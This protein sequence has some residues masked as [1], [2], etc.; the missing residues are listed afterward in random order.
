MG[1]FTRKWFQPI[2]KNVWWTIGFIPDKQIDRGSDSNR[3]KLARLTFEDK[4]IFGTAWR[5]LGRSSYILISVCGGWNTS[6]KNISSS[7]K[8]SW[9]HHLVLV[10]LTIHGALRPKIYRKSDL[11]QHCHHLNHCNPTPS[12]PRLTLSLRNLSKADWWYMPSSPREVKSTVF[13]RRGHV[14]PSGCHPRKP[15]NFNGNGLVTGNDALFKAAPAHLLTFFERWES[16]SWRGR[17]EG[18]RYCD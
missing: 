6:G 2:W 4:N 18:P 7:K 16:V 17:K 15:Q 13:L 11:F 9:K 14:T 12:Q 10:F 5:F 8:L 3:V 1:M